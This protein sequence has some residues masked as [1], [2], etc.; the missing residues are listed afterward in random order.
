VQS[1]INRAMSL[2]FD[3]ALR[4]GMLVALFVIVW[5]TSSRHAQA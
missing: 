1:S 5:R 3:I 4:L 2:L